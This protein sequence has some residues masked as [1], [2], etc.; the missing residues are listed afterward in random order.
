MRLDEPEG[1]SDKQGFFARVFGRD[2][3]IDAQQFR[4][5]VAGSGGEGT[6]VS[7]QDKDGKPEASATGAKILAQITEQMR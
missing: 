5:L 2:P 1:V 7:V 4:I 3:K 6:D